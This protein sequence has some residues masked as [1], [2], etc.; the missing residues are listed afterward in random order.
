MGSSLGAFTPKELSI[1]LVTYYSF[2]LPKQEAFMKTRILFIVISLFLVVSAGFTGILAL[3][4]ANLN[5]QIA[6]LVNQLK[7][8]QSKV[9][10]FEMQ[11][12]YENRYNVSIYLEDQHGFIERGVVSL[13]NQAEVVETY[14]MILQ[15]GSETK[16]NI[17]RLGDVPALITSGGEWLPLEAV[18]GEIIYLTTYSYSDGPK[19]IGY[20]SCYT[21]SNHCT[22]RITETGIL[23]QP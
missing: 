21:N 7:I 22:I 18:K 6:T 3:Q 20:Y 9:Q 16:R 4:N 14:R 2:N 17:Y 10:I 15:D 11:N 1:W 13:D 8:S 19:Y 12:A 23:A 5:N